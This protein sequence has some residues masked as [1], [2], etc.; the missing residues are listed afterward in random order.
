MNE[1]YAEASVKQKASPVNLLIKALLIAA[2]IFV[3]LFGMAY[4]GPFSIVAVGVLILV[5]VLVFPYLSVEVEY[6]FCDGQL[7]FDKI[8]SGNKRKTAMRID[9]ENV[10]Q[11]APVNSHA[12]DAYQ[13]NPNVKTIDF[14]S[15]QRDIHPHV[16]IVRQGEQLTRLLF[17]PS[18]KMIAVIK[19]KA[20]RKV[21]DY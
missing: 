15:R 5:C 7:D 6:V 17:E 12:L 16:I 14:T 3:L 20:P 13:N 10:E 11:M 4:F 9:F 1:S 19:Q 18:E 2:I 21:S 8:Y